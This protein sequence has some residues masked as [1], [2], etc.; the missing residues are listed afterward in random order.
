MLGKLQDKFPGV[1][2]HFSQYLQ[3]NVSEAVSE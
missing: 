2:F 3:D 1:E